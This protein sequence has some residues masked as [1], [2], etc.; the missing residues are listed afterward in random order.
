MLSMV[1]R[2]LKMLLNN[3]WDYGQM[4]LN[5]QKTCTSMRIFDYFHGERKEDGYNLTEER[6][7][8]NR[9]IWISPMLPQDDVSVPKHVLMNRCCCSENW[10]SHGLKEQRNSL[11]KIVCDAYGVFLKGFASN[12][13]EKICM[14]RS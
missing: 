8:K 7:K 5:L 11:L 14:L 9:G 6:K 12:R 2:F 13:S 3:K 1:D 4:L 10:W